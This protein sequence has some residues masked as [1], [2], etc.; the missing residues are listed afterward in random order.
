M[1]NIRSIELKYLFF[2]DKLM[3]M[4]KILIE[5][6]YFL[7]NEIVEYRINFDFWT[8]RKINKILVNGKNQ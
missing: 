6:F 2:S 5:S 4:E 3:V 1:I 8:L 7:N